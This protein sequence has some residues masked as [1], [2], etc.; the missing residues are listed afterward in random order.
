MTPQD[1]VCPILSAGCDWVT[2]TQKFDSPE[3]EALRECARD[4]IAGS[5]LDGV[6][7][8]PQSPQGFQGAGNEF[9]FMGVRE[10]LLMVRVS[11]GNASDFLEKSKEYGT[12]F[13]PTRI[14]F[15]VTAEYSRDDR[16]F[17][18]RILAA[19]RRG[20][21]V[22]GWQSRAKAVLY[23]GDSRDTGVTIGSRVGE[24]YLR[25]YHPRSAGH[26]EFSD[27]AIRFEVEYKGDRADKAYKMAVKAEGVEYLAASLLQ[28][29]LRARNVVEPWFSARDIPRLKTDFRPTDNERRFQWFENSVMP[30]LQKLMADPRYSDKIHESYT[31]SRALA[32]PLKR[33]AALEAARGEAAYWKAKDFE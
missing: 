24:S 3:G 2:F 22:N 1:I 13:H 26:L 5:C 6:G 31:K 11:G 4:W 29:E 19:V 8:K 20:E 14:D 30:A 28:G 21:K 27:R 18:G 9:G 15:Q 10:D 25:A 16:S 7:L 17:A 32:L 12:G 33:M 23:Q